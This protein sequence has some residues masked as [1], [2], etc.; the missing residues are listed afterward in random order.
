MAAAA[1]LYCNALQAL[2]NGININSQLFL[3]PMSGDGET[4]GKAFRSTEENRKIPKAGLKEVV[5]GF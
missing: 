1:L 2:L 4:A 3:L 5:W